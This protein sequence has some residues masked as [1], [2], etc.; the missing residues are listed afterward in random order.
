MGDCRRIL[1]PPQRYGNSA[2][3]RPGESTRNAADSEK[4][5]N[6]STHTFAGAIAV[7]S[8]AQFIISIPYS[9]FFLGVPPAMSAQREN[10]A[11]GPVPA[12]FSI[13]NVTRLA[14]RSFLRSFG[15]PDLLP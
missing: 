1:V 5:A 4:F 14:L 13:G 15:K 7:D 8:L 11:K 9:A 12:A 2:Q 3:T 6:T 10:V